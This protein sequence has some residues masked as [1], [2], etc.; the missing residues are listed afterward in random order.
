MELSEKNLNGHWAED[1]NG[2]YS[3]FIINEAIISK[4]CILG[5]DVE[6]CFEGASIGKVQFSYNED[7]KK[8]LFEMMKNL[9]FALEGGNMENN[10]ETVVIEE[11]A[12][13]TI[14]ESVQTEIPNVEYNLEEIPEYVE[15]NTN[16][17]EL[18][19]NYETLNANYNSL[20]EKYDELVEFKKTVD[21]KEKEDMINSFYM[22][23]DED[24]KD[25][26]DNIDKYSLDDIEAK[27]SIICFRNK[28][29]FKKEE[30]ENKTAI[31]TSFNLETSIDS[32]ESIP[33]WVK[34]A[35]N[36][37]KTEE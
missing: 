33:A 28:V 15:L 32:E 27:L 17:S 7:F 4:L 37:A 1:E 10:K 19:T 5:E 14:E 31:N 11:K 18:L 2:W 8:Q 20:K 6:P 21:K 13:E 25:V 12:E 24:K 29:S 30:E 22:L 35:L 3:F 16:Y 23:T 36:V 9:Q 34:A 26:V